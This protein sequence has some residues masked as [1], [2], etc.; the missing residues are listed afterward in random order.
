MTLD[1]DASGDLKGLNADHVESRPTC[2]RL[3][4][5]P[6]SDSA[7]F[8]IFDQS[9]MTA[10]EDT[11]PLA[12]GLIDVIYLEGHDTRDLG[13]HGL[14]GPQND[15]SAGKGEVHRNGDRA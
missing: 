2:P 6:C 11:P 3:D 1:D 8:E 15:G 13:G 5:E 14:R 7:L 12:H 9:G 10:Y 4:I